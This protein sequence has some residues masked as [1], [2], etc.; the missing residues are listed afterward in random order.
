MPSFDCFASS[1]EEPHLELTLSQETI[2]LLLKRGVPK[3]QY[4]KFRKDSVS[5][6][7]ALSAAQSGFFRGRYKVM[8]VCVQLYELGV[9]LIAGV[10]VGVAVGAFLWFKYFRHSYN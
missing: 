1:S 10:F 8:N 3:K 5:R 2:R 9:Y 7:I 4:I 6:I